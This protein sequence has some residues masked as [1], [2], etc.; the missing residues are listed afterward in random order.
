MESFFRKNEIDDLEIRKRMI[1][2]AYA[3]LP[4]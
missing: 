3:N 2:R 4:D 1:A